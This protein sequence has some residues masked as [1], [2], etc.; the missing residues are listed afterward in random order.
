MF[1]LLPAAVA[2]V[3]RMFVKEPEQW[4]NAA[5]TAAPARVR[6]IFSP[7]LRPRTISA[8]IVAIIALIAWWSCNAFIPVVATTMAQHAAGERALDV[9]A[10][11]ALVESW[12]SRRPWPSTSAGS[13]ARCSPCRSPS[14]SAG[15]RC[16]WCTSQQ[17]RSRCSRPSASTFRRDAPVP[18]LLHRPYR[19]RRVRQLHLLSTGAVPDAAALHRRGFCYN[20]GRVIAAVGVFAVGAVA[21]AGRGDPGI[22]FNVR[23]FLIGFVP[24]VGLLCC[25]GSSRPAARRCP[26]DRVR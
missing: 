22:V 9:M 13:S 19:V 16:T 17:P 5:A 21:A 6:E 26:T 18:V 7:E 4:A 10:T 15:A 20:I 23:M 14:V 2:F 1:G 12:K 25:D 11:T 3:V 8:L 24:I